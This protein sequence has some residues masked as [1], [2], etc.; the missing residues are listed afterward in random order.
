MWRQLSGSERFRFV[1]CVIGLPAAVLS[2]TFNA[3]GHHWVEAAIPALLV[4]SSSYYLYKFATRDRESSHRTVLVGLIL[5]VN[6]LAVAG[7]F[8]YQQLVKPAPTTLN[9]SDNSFTVRVPPGWRAEAPRVPPGWRQEDLERLHIASMGRL[10]VTS[11]S[12]DRNMS[13]TAHPAGS[14]TLQQW[15]QSVMYGAVHVAH[16]EVDPG[17]S[18]QPTAVGG[19]PALRT[20]YT[21]PG[22]PTF[23]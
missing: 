18:L 19:E 20:T 11:A 14:L 16:A 9:A 2:T 10:Y 21:V 4:F 17:G 23:L 1:C 7:F 22:G 3:I 6:V 13:V 5:A 8:G 12:H 15:G